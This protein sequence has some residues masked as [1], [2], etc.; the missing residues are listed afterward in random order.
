MREG[1]EEFRN[2]GAF[3]TIFPMAREVPTEPSR[4]ARCMGLFPAVG[5]AIGLLLA[6]IDW[7][8]APLLPR[9]VRNNFV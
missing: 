2:A 6:V 1:W 5:L 7:T 8:L 9:Q 4:L 3:L